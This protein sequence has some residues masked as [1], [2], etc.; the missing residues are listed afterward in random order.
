MPTFEHDKLFIDG[1]WTTPSESGVIDVVDPATENVIGHV[2]NGSAADVDAAVTAARRAFDPLISVAERR[3]RLDRVIAAMEKRLPEIAELITAEMGAP[4]RISQSV[5]TQV[6]LAVAKGFAEVLD[7]FEFEERIGN[8]LVLRE[9]YGVVGA[10]TPWNYPLYQV[11]AKVVPAIAAGCTV[12]LK[13]SNE[14]PL[15]VF[16]FV[17]ACED[18]G[19]PPGTINLVSG[20]GRVIGEHIAAHPD[21]D[22]VSF[23]GSTGVGARVG[24]LAGQTIKKVALELGGKSANVIL[25]GADLATAVKVGVGNAFLNGGQTCMAWT[26]MLVP[27]S[28]YDEALDL[29]ESAVSRYTVGDPRDPATRIGPSASRSQF[30][31]VRGFIER[32]QRDGARLLVGGAEPIR[33]VG[34]F[35]APTVFADVD[36]DSELG[37]EEVFGPVLAITPYTDAD[38]ALRIANGTPYGLSGAV[39]AGSDDEAIDFARRVHTG[40]L[41]INGGAYNPS[42]P[43]G[44]YKKS[45]IGREL[46]RFGFEEYLQT[47]SLQLKERA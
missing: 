1:R 32:A 11:V 17:E 45:G 27:Q 41:D 33:D 5:Q 3:E 30:D 39:W 23:T 6:P 10:I 12:V 9:P 40:Q 7:T 42:A 21:V 20:P 16:A 4:V 34:F 25:E 18:A 15:S 14:A 36:P 8:S 46:G 19:L 35:L 24:E 13:P 2:P 26:R 38:D 47:K 43:F 22:F 44:G 31:T 29:V 28:R 37:Q